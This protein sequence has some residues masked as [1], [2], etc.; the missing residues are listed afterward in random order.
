M[1][2][3]LILSLLSICSLLSFAQVECDYQPDV[4]SDYLIG[5]SDILAVLGL[6]GEVDLDQDGIWDSTDLCTDIDAVSYTHLTLPT[7]CSV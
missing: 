1:K 7:I 5:V 3:F 4:E 2:N 6:F